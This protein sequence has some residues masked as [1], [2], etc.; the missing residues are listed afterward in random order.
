MII[1]ENR[2]AYHDY[3]ILEI[4]EAGLVLSGPEVKS[5]KSGQVDLKGSYVTVDSRGEAWLVNAYLA[6]YKPARLSLKSYQPHQVRKL[7]LTRKELNYLIGKQKERGVSLIPLKIFLRNR[8]VK[9]EIGVGV[10]KKKYDKREQ[11]KK[12]EF[13]RRKQR[14]MKL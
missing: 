9:L 5:A 6:P 1:S 7:L 3:Q 8:L 14:M 10:G 13:E 12:R 4:F 2:R 11:I